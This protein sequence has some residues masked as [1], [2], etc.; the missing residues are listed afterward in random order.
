LVGIYGRERNAVSV[1]KSAGLAG[2]ADLE[3]KSKSCIKNISHEIH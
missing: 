3:K 1:L 2:T